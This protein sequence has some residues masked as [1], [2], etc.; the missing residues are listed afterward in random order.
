MLLAAL[1][2]PAVAAAVVV[3]PSPAAVSP[4]SCAM[5]RGSRKALTWDIRCGSF[6]GFVA[7]IGRFCSAI[8]RASEIMAS[9]PASC[10]AVAVERPL[11]GISVAGFRTSVGYRTMSVLPR[12]SDI[13]CASVRSEKCQEAHAQQQI[14]QRW[15]RRGRPSMLNRDPRRS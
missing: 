15:D 3:A 10:G 13:P 11:H 4:K 14:A 8:R 7:A 1:H 9:S 2:S 12:R 5:C 6:A